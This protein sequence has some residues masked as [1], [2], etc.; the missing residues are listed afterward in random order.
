LG[1]AHA[2]SGRKEKGTVARENSDYPSVRF[3]QV[4]FLLRQRRTIFRSVRG[5][6]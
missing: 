3:R 4:T 2:V 1:A 6:I 5:E